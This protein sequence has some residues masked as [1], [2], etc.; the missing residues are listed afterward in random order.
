MG[1]LTR[2]K[3]PFLFAF[4]LHF[5]NMLFSFLLKT[6]LILFEKQQRQQ[7]YSRAD[8]TGAEHG[9]TSRKKTAAAHSGAPKICA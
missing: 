4:L 8:C 9:C 7:I 2:C 5:C 6:F 1:F 3:R